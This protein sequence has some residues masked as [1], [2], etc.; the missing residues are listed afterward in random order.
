MKYLR[1]T[2]KTVLVEFLMTIKIRVVFC[3]QPIACR[4]RRFCMFG[5]HKV[6]QIACR[7]VVKREQWH[8]VL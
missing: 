8:C 5:I 1:A 4:H 3:R 6:N 2:Q 7:F